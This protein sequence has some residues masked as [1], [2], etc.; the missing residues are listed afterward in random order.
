MT[1]LLHRSLG[2]Q[3]EIEG[4]L[5]PALWMAEVDAHQLESAI[6]NLAVNARDAMPEGGKLTIDTANVFLDE[7]NTGADADV[8]PGEYVLL[9][10]TDTGSGIAEDHLARVFEPF[11]TTKELG[12]GTG[13][14]LSMVYGFVKQSGGH[15]A[16]S[17]Q[18]G[19]GTTVR[20][21]L[22][23][24]RGEQPSPKPAGEIGQLPVSRDEVVLIVEDNDHVREYGATALIELGYK[25]LQ[26]SDAEAALPILRDAQRI[27]LLFTDVVL[28]GSNGRVLAQQAAALRPDL[29]VLFTT[30][31][32]RDVIMHQGRL[33]PGLELLPKPFT[34]DQLAMRVRE[35]LDKRDAVRSEASV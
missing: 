13:L 21:Y 7:S 9:S 23:R 35:V 33:E 20:L 6:L 25:V 3:I 27:D 17:S 26:A 31:Y 30:G 4:M 18:V 32:S 12:R 11:F 16:I 5:S 10:V 14:G 28:P 29:T 1:E 24:Y 19:C 22:P 8:A 15:V 34:F 2:E